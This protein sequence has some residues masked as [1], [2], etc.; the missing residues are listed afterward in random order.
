MLDTFNDLCSNSYLERKKI[1]QILKLLKAIQAFAM[2]EYEKYFAA[3]RI[4][5]QFHHS[6]K[7]LNE[8]RYSHIKNTGGEVL[9]A[10]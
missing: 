5:C 4:P 10:L 3:F 8:L 1:Y 9:C 6:F 7:L 2:P